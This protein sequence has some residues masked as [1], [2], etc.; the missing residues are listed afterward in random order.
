MSYSIELIDPVS[1]ETLHVED[2]HFMRG[3][4]FAIGGTTELC[5]DVTYNYSKRL[6]EVMGE[7]GIRSIYGLTGLES[8][9]VLENAIA[10]LGDDVSDNYWDATDGNAKRALINLKTMAQMRPDG[11]WDGD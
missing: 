3:G 4:T 5:L 8:I 2:N 1:K 11:I 7:K 6:Y 10:E 9:P